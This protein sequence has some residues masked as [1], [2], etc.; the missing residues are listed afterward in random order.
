MSG[1]GW[2]VSGFA[3]RQL[4]AHLIYQD[5]EFLNAACGKP[6]MMSDGVTSHPYEFARQVIK[7]RKCR[8]CAR[9]KR[10]KETL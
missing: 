3:H 7:V 2:Q 8:V 10:A 4:V 9:T 6:W 1:T 5:G